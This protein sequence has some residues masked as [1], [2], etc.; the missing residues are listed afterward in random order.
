M[1]PIRV[2]MLSKEK[3]HH[4]NM[5]MYFVF[6]KNIL[7]VL[8]LALCFAGM[9]LLG[10]KWVLDQH[11]TDL[12]AHTISVGNKQSDVTREIRSLNTILVE[13]QEIQKEYIHWSAPMTELGAAASTGVSLDGMTVNTL[14]G[15]LTIVGHAITRDALLGYR[16]RIEALDFIS[17]V[18]IPITQFTEKTDLPFTLSATV[19][20]D[21]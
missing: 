9:V 21:I 13:A 5:M 18:T 6:T 12:A 19:N 14:E 7:E 3:R 15:K 16:D 20:F 1:Y 4:L 10:G 8:L 11:F 17:E 2:N